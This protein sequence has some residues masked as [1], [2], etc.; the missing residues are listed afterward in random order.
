MVDM[1]IIQINEFDCENK[2]MDMFLWNAIWYMWLR[3]YGK[4]IIDEYM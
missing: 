4:C 2:K 3:W 1:I